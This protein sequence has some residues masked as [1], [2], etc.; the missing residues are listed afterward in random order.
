MC[1]T[2]AGAPSGADG[3]FARAELE[4]AAG[5][6]AA[7]LREEAADV[8]TVYDPAGGYGHPDHVRVHDAGVRAAELAG[9]PVVLEA[10][11]DRSLLLRALRLVAWLP[12]VPA[13]FAPAR[14]RSAYTAPEH[15][16]HRVDVRRFARHKRAAMAAHVSQAGADAGVRTLAVLLKLP[17]PLYRRVLG[18]EWFAE[19][20]REPARPL[21]DDIFASLRDGSRVRRARR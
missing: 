17:M 9:T 20:G 4:E 14:F 8:L 21:L 15:L 12:G 7:I 5:R 16:T 6:L 1:T 2:S 11:V 10:T 3:A 19:R 13:D 18:T